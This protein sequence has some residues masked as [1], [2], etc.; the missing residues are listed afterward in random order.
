MR[1]EVFE[2]GGG[3]PAMTAPRGSPGVE[4]P[5]TV[6]VVGT[7]SIGLRHARN[8]RALGHRVLAWDTDPAR[9]EAA[10]AL[11]AAVAGSLDEGLSAG[12]RAALICTPPAAHV[13]PARLALR[14]GLDLFV[15]KPLAEALAPAQA[16]VEEAERRG[17]LLAVGMN[18]RFLPSL[19]RV[20]ALLEDGRIGRVLAASAWFGAYLPSW[21]PGQDY[22][23]GYAVSRAQGGGVLLDAIHELDYLVWLLG[24]PVEAFCT[25]GHVSGLAGDTEDLAEVTLRYGDGALAQVH[26]DYL[27]RA[28]RRD[29]EVLGE[30]GLVTWDYPTRSVRLTLAGGETQVLGGEGDPPEEDMYVEEIRHFVRCLSGAERP[31]VDGRAGLASL[32]L[33]DAARASAASGRWVKA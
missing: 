33:V 17:R 2:I 4:T 25:A 9:R 32:R 20:K 29:L 3:A 22:R 12:P 10:R 27:R 15:E 1:V 19:R 11:G 30:D 18:L 8:L 7:G 5:L 26:L 24:E 6:L 31:W 28:Y 13:E 16:L 23:Q 21:R 14:A